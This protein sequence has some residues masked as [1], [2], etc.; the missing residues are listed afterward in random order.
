VKSLRAPLAG[1]LL[2][3]AAT[4]PAW[5]PGAEFLVVVGLG[6]W[7][8]LATNGAPL[9]RSWLL[10][11]VHLAWFSWSL[12]HVLV[13]AWIAIALLGGL[14]YALGTLAV[15]AAPRRLA[16]LAFGLAT[17]GTSWLRA[18]MPEICYPHGQPCHA[19]W[20]WPTLLGS[21]VLGGEALANGLLGAF[22][23]AL[24]GLARS[25]RLAA[26]PWPAALR[27]LAV[28]AGAW[29][30]CTAAGHLLAAA[31]RADGAAS[32]RVAAVEPGFHL[33][34]EVRGLTREQAMARYR[35]LVDERLLAPTR[36]LI[37]AADPPDVVLWPES[38]LL[39][40]LDR[41]S[42]VSGAGRLRL[43]LPRS[44]ALLVLGAGVQAGDA[45]P[46]PAALA[47]DLQD[48]RVL[49]HQEKRCL[50]PGGEVQPFV[51]WLPAS[52]AA[53]IRSAFE[54]ALGSMPEAT[55]G[56][57]LPPLR[58]AA[59][60]PFGALLCY[61]N[62][63]AHPARDQVARGARWLA[64]LSNECWYEGGGE[65]VQLVAM[66]VVRALE[67]GTPIVRCTQDGWTV[68]VDGRG[69]LRDALPLVAADPG[70]A[71]VLRAEVPLGLGGLPGGAVLRA[72]AGPAAGIA[73]GLLLLGG[74]RRIGRRRIDP[75]PRPGTGS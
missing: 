4:P 54:Q 41:A 61:D 75:V 13:A 50:V 27:A 21:V 20:Q 40:E 2:L 64:V 45:P 10:G 46:T 72:S 73:V 31:H 47:V 19:F 44:Q 71:R 8:A 5:F 56:A 11:C 38:S 6:V 69:R 37:T 53:A 7:Y 25:W 66:T 30:G 9:W 48:G 55:P 60:V 68:W 51:R 26:P 39:D 36:A 14:Y 43:G 74:I 3:A 62:A 33:V 17:A 63:F 52:W 35:Q 67:T 59:G 29:G 22:A 23:A 70:H 42:V 34:R 12:R 49:A 1:G 65:L 32:V 16:V 57:L 58:D 28:A 18:H 24:A 15:R